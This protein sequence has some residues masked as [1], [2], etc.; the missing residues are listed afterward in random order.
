MQ[1]IIVK[2]FRCFARRQE[3]PL[4]RITLLVGENSAGKSSFLAA[5]RLAWAVSHGYESPDFNEEP[6]ALGSY[7]DIANF[8]GGKAG[9]ATEF[10][11]GCTLQP[12]GR[13]KQA[14]PA[15]AG[16]VT[17]EES[18]VRVTRRPS[19]RTWRASY[20]N[21]SVIINLS[22]RKVAVEPEGGTFT[23]P[24]SQ[25]YQPISGAH[26]W[27]L[28]RA[29]FIDTPLSPKHESELAPAAAALYKEVDALVGHVW[30]RQPQRPV[31]IAPIRSEPER[32]YQPRKELARARGGSM[33]FYLADALAPSSKTR[34]V[35]KT[36]LDGYGKASGLFDT[37]GVKPL[38]VEG[39]V[40]QLQ[41]KATG[42]A[43]NV[44]DVGYGVSQVLPVLVDAYR[45]Q[46]RILLIQQPEV[47]LHPRAQ[48][49]L[50]SFIYDQAASSQTR[51]V[52]ETHSDYLA[53]RI[54]MEVRDH[55]SDTA[56][57]L[58]ASDVLILYFEQ[59]GHDVNVHP[60]HV[61]ETGSLKDAPSS[62]RE[63]FLEEERKFVTGL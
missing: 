37:L 4:G 12:S 20:G 38:D 46:D 24:D 36:L 50:G 13:L 49:E 27:Q 8:R 31:A 5:I 61:D 41:V 25:P 28:L 3:L 60:I 35:L 7:R 17:V 57:R 48:A 53:N 39:G 23:I 52:V 32:V 11:I 42:P 51:F 6:F 55:A 18:F 10:S 44:V 62:Y 58:Q 47:H 26:F 21:V 33:P 1:T 22:E 45:Y 2:S 40:F 30:Q 34:P 56:R 43:R 14:I 16:V 19:P 15:A 29:G 63:F 54:L 9:R 59:S